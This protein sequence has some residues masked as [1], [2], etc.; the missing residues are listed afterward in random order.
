M[1]PP[2]RP[3]VIAHRGA[4]AVAPEHTI[5][6]FERALELGA[7]GLQLDVHLSRDDQPVVIHDYTLER[8]T[9]GAGAVRALTVRE[10]KRLDVGRWFGGAFG[11]QRL[12]TLQEVLERFRDRT[13]FWIE[14]RG[15]STLYPGLEER[16]VGLL[17]VYD[18]LERS[19]LQSLDARALRIMRSLSRDVRL[20]VLVAHRRFD[21]MAD[22]AP[23][24]NA[25]CPSVAILE[26][27]ER[28][29]IRGA[30]R[31][32]HVWTVNEP[33]LVDRLVDWRADGIVTDRPE[34]VWGRLNARG[35]AARPGNG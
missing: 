23:G 1:S 30:G 13:R 2:D 3:L 22:L 14:L 5:A 21:P 15:G 18:V 29:A 34:L 7:D 33:V 10:L 32:C 17:E 31:E 26:E 6:A 8:T 25:V 24:L 16:V 27:A 11:G 12:Q 19:L 28:A 9:D 35:R 4:S 20:G